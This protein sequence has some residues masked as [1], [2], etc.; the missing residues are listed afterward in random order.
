[1]QLDFGTRLKHWRMKR[2]MTQA[3]LARASGMTQATIA[4]YEVGRILP[5][6][7]RLKALLEALQA[8]TE[9]FFYEKVS[10]EDSSEEMPQKYKLTEGLGKRLEYWRT[11]RGMSQTE[12]AELAG[13]SDATVSSLGNGLT[14]PR[15]DTLE[16]LLN[17][18]NVPIGEFFRRKYVD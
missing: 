8:P 16:L 11:K 2:E 10:S 14:V 7:Y 12:L 17:A 1:M 4:A 5:R 9:E 13:L 15:L 18:L 6:K 3:A